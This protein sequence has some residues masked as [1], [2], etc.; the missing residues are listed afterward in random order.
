MAFHV[1]FSRQAKKQLAAIELKQRRMIL[2]WVGSHLEGCE[3]PRGVDGSK[4]LKGTKAGWRYRVGSYR[5]LATIQ[6][7]E[8]VIDVVRVGH[9]QDVYSDL[10]KM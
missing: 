3:N 2:A 5:I 1:L 10:P 7:E 8:L 9:R 4:Q 6:D